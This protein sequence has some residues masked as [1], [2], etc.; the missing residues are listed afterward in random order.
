IGVTGG[1]LMTR[2]FQQ[3]LLGISHDTLL[4]GANADFYSSLEGFSPAQL[5]RFEGL[6]A[7]VYATFVGH[8]ADGRSMTLED[9]DAVAGGR[10]WTGRRAVDLGL[11][12]ELGGLDKALAAARQEADADDLSALAIDFFPRPPTLWDLLYRRSRPLLS[13][14]QLNL[15]DL[16]EPRTPQLLELPPGLLQLTRPF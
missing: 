4:R 15:E 6:M 5:A 8:V 10:V 3:E 9:V 13:V 11:A 16:L 14:R 2:R 7:D 12:D 1:K